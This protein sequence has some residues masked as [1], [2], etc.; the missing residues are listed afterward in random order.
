MSRGKLTGSKEDYVK[1][2]WH[3]T[4]SRQPATGN[5]LSRELSVTPP[6]VSRALQRLQADGLAKTAADGAASLT[7][8]G[9]KLAEDLIRRHRLVERLLTDVLHMSWD[10][11][12]E[13]AERLEHAISPTVEARLVA[14]FGPQA[15]CPHGWPV[16]ASQ[17][18]PRDKEIPMSDLR[19]GQP[20]Q[21][22]RVYERE[23]PLLQYFSRI[24]L[25][26]GVQVKLLE[27]LPD[28]SVT[29]EIGNQ[30]V[31]LGVKALTL[32]W[33]TPA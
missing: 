10:E 26:P 8:R 12:H 11:V 9:R 33:V 27:R 4:A 6:A 29:A 22:A 3:L 32:T 5:R 20:A 15:R 19:L 16:T 1:A 28:E 13:E 25:R 17:S 2:I 24:G 31:T 14:L 7:P 21:V 23:R 30:R 18:G